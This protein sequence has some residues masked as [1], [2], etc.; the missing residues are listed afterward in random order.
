[1]NLLFEFLK[2]L[3]DTDLQKLKAQTFRGTTDKVFRA[4]LAQAEA[5]EF[6]RDK[7]Q[8]SLQLSDSHFDKISS[9]LLSKSYR[10]LIPEEGSEL[11]K[12]LSYRVTYVKHFYKELSRQQ[13]LIEKSKDRKLKAQF[14]KQSIN[15]MHFNLSIMNKD[16][17]VMKQLGKKYLAALPKSEL[18]TGRMW[19]S[20]RLIF[21]S[22]DHLFAAA[23]I[24]TRSKKIFAEITKLGDPE[25]ITDPDLL[26]EYYWVLTYYYISIEQFATGA[27]V[28]GRAVEALKKYHTEEVSTNIVRLE[29]KRAELLYFSSRFE[30]SFQK[31]HE[32]LNGPLV[33]VIHE[34]G[35]YITKYIQV[36]LIT[37]HLKE[38]KK[39]VENF[40]GFYEKRIDDTM[41]VRE[42]FSC[43]KYYLFA[44]EFDKAFHFLQ[45]GFQR[46]P[47]GKYFQYEVE[48]RNLQVALFYLSGREEDILQ[49]CERNIKYLRSHGYGV[50]ESDF[51]YFYI[52]ARAIYE[53]K[54]TGR[55]LRPSE[56]R[57]LKRYNAGSYALYGRLL[58]MMLDKK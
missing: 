1:M 54:T 13:R 33:D 58:Q 6:H 37:G 56:K 16:G 11:L 53:S 15:H 47:K 4:I 51:P 40:L 57:K 7:I 32:V 14:Y 36:S 22:I 44:G 3:P 26:F 5:G 9:E 19:V 35:Y 12:F 21:N 46:N 50:R 29:M 52:I 49:M 27:E 10:T 28:A 48:L 39:M 30:E 43:I 25:K 2:N 55:D 45:L 31:Y 20:C 41:P 23:H 18:A 8:K 34:R 42:V 38:A 24:I 17:E